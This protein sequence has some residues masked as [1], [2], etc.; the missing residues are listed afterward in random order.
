M[1]NCLTANR[2]HERRGY[3]TILGSVGFS[4]GRHYWEIKLEAYGHEDDIYIG[5]CKQD[6]NCNTI[7]WEG[8]TSWGWLCTGAK[9][10]WP[11]SIGI[12]AQ[13]Y[14]EYA[15]IAE[16]LGVL[17]EFGDDQVGHLTFYQHGRTLGKAFNNIPPGTYY[18]CVSLNN[19]E[20]TEV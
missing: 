4:S 10:V 5:I 14:G 11:G 7:A 16:V 18:P 8:G 3:E 1:N 20:S 13:E 9:K 19:N 2:G 12:S 15:K 6:T 17:L